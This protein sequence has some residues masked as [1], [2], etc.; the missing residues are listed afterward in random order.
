MSL[1][2]AVV[3]CMTPGFL[4]ATS[5]QYEFMILG[6]EELERELRRHNIPLV[7]LIGEPSEE[8]SRYSASQKAAVVVTDFSPLRL[9]RQWR[10]RIAGEL[11]CPL[12]EVDAHNIVPCWEASGKQEYAAYTFRPKVQRLL[13]EYLVDIPKLQAHPVDWTDNP[14]WIDWK[15]TRR[16]A[17]LTAGAEP[18]NKMPGER[19]ANRRLQRFLRQG[20]EH[21]D[22]R[23]NDPNAD[24]QSGL[25]PY[26]HFGQISAQR[27]AW[28][29][30]EQI[31]PALAEGF[32]EELIIRRELSDNFCY[33]CSDY[34]AI[35]AFPEWALK[36]LDEHKKDPREF[37]YTQEQLE[38][39]ET[40]DPLWNA[41]QKE[42]VITG[43]MPGYLRMYWAKKILEWS[44]DPEQALAVTIELNDRYELDGRDP[45]GYAG[46]A[47]SI[48]GVHDRAWPEREIFGKVRYMSYDGC[49]RKFDVDAYVERVNRIEKTGSRP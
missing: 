30:K 44:P 31:D 46:A 35:K 33:Y 41:A 7:L 43:C 25:S 27:V 11:Q 6:L 37:L 17:G 21:Y 9:P 13:P 40:H 32:L 36:T 34:D 20:L 14:D 18:Y 45:N 15:Q 48:G 47:W 12:Y 38:V 22:A 5:R 1:P 4:E 29:V 24:A 19:A 23:R 39:A 2:L 8:V 42:M 28:E 26:F 3:F 10:Q 49:R 16:K